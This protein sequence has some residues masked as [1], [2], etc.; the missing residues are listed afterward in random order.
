MALPIP[1][2]TG[3]VAGAAITYVFKDQSSMQWINDVSDKLKDTTS[4]LWGSLKTTTEETVED[5]KK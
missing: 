1:F 2:I 4:S 3:A 5:V